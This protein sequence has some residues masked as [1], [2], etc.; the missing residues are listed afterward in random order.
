MIWLT[1]RQFRTPA[2]AMLGALA[3]AAI[4][5][6]VTGTQLR[7]SYDSALASCG[8]QGGCGSAM[9]A[10]AAHYA[11]PSY[12]FSALLTAVPG[13]VG[14][15]WGAPL[16]AR[17]L[18]AG[19]HR[20]VWNQSVTRTRWLMVKLLA[21]GLAA[22][23]GTGLLSLLVSWWAAPIDRI[24]NNRFIPLLF[25]ARGVAPL[26][27]AAFAFTL[28]ACAGLLLRR[29]VPAMAVTLTVFTA[30]QLL[31][32]IAIRPHL[33]TPVRA[34]VALN[35]AAINSARLIGTTGRG[36][37]AHFEAELTMPGA[38]VLSGATPAINAAGRTVT[39]GQTCSAAARA[40]WTSCVADAGLR[41]PIS[42]EPADR[43]WTVQWSETAF[44]LALSAGLAGFCAWWLR[45]LT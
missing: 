10:L 30:V 44:F 24:N 23:V 27:Y 5:L 4:F 28:G 39:M 17:E 13:I 3:A 37:D 31:M 19:T 43:Y 20:L 8:G 29:S 22:V 36:P 34:D 18:E 42:Y 21:V 38:W 33:V 14:A 1:W 25:D 32:P 6:V 26:G 16:I 11:V 40:D 2:L 7:H 45:R 41:V 9:S 15:F 12:V 35:A